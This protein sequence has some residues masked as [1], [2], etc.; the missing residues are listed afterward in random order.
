M[1]CPP[2]SGLWG[3]RVVALVAVG[4]AFASASCFPQ[5]SAQIRRPPQSCEES[6]A[7]AVEMAKGDVFCVQAILS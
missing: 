4:C 1:R 2:R 3:A 7:L 5:Q 6:Q